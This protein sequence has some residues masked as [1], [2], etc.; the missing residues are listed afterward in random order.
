MNAICDS[1]GT[2]FW[3]QTITVKP[4]TT[5]TFGFSHAHLNP[6]QIGFTINGGANQATINTTNGWQ[7]FQ[8]TINSG[9]NTSLTIRLNE[10]T[11]VMASADFAVDDIY[12]IETG[13]VCDATPLDSDNDGIANQ[14]DLDSD[15]DGCRDAIEGGASFTTA[16]LT[17]AGALSGTVS[18]AVATSGV[19]TI[20]G[21]GQTIGTSQNAVVQDASCPPLDSDGDGVT[22]SSDLDDDNDGILD[23]VEGLICYYTASEANVI[24]S[25]STGLT[26]STGTTSLLSNGVLTTAA[27]NFAFTAGQALANANLFTVTYPTPVNL[28][29]L[30]IVNATSLGASATAK[31]QGSLNG[32]TWVDLTSAAVSL[33]TTA[34][35]VF[36]VN[37]NAGEYLYYRI[38]WR[39]HGHL[40]CQSCF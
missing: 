29:S 32:T 16:N 1:A 37:Q 33:S 28:T 10:L 9:S 13:L 30:T 20:A 17:P 23:V 7:Q 18:S 8:T 36:T 3:R 5:Y 22:N 2:D 12:L 11:R 31:L 27:P 15:G 14:L 38:F 21:F 19:P 35:K 4:N 39:R 6:A 34:N 24:A 25:I 40:T 26:I